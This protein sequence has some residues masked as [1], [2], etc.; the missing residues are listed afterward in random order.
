[1]DLAKDKKNEKSLIK[2]RN[3]VLE[4]AQRKKRKIGVNE[5]FDFEDVPVQNRYLYPNS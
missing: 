4:V 2:N 1:M 5:P 3:F